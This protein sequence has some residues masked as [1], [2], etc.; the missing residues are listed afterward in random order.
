MATI[1]LLHPGEM[2]AAVGGCLVSVGHEVLWDPAGRSRA[3]TGRALAA[4]LSGVS[5]ADLVSRSSVIFSICPPHAAL[6]VAGQVAAAGFG[7][8]YVDANAISVATAARVASVVEASGASYV[9]GGIIGLPPEV[10]GRTRLYLSGAGAGEVRSLFGGSA[11][12][13]RI[14]EGQPFAASAVKMA[15]AAWTKGSGALLLAA[16]AL[17]RAEGVE[18]TLL[19]EWAMSQPSLSAQSGRSAAAA[20]AKGWR[21]VAEMEEI[22]AS[23]AAAGL[24]PGF[25]QAAAEIYDRAARGAGGAGGDARGPEANGADETAAGSALDTVMSALM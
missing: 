3:S 1:G 5:L 20:A 24:P 4:G 11:L 14:A 10:A 21:W 8:G 25:H 2:G 16:R 23:M 7:G 6:D 22:A 19:G 13:A 12:D 17:A 15:Y 9:D 18:E